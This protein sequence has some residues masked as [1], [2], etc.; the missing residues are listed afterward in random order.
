MGQQGRSAEAFEQL[1]LLRHWY[2]QRSDYDRRS[3]LTVDEAVAYGE[4]LLRL[5]RI[6]AQWRG[7]GQAHRAA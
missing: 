7:Y 5:I 6:R 1:W 4:Q 3:T 2:A